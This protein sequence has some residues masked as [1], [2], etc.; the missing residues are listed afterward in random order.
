[1]DPTSLTL[2]GRLRVNPAEADWDRLH[3]LYRPL[4]RYWIGRVP[5]LRDEG[6]DV[7]QEVFAAVVRVIPTFAHQHTG[8]FRAWL[9]EITTRRIREC[10]RKRRNRPLVGVGTD[11][12]EHFLIRLED[13]HGDLAAE[14][15]AEHNRQVLE[16]L[17]AAVRAD[18]EPR[19]WDMFR[20]VVLDGRRVDDIAVEFGVTAAAVLQN[21]ARV[22]R[23][24][25]QEAG[26]LLD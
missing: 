26:E 14:W 17:S 20:A 3:A 21:K 15:D 7:F 22:L 19:T 4:I 10:V 25:R 23:R 24:L 6:D 13:P 12:T 11:E 5:D 1:M 2:L 18:F 8:S 16:R 9:R